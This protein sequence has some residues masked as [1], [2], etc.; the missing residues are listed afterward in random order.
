MTWNG[1]LEVIADETGVSV[2]DID[3]HDE[4]VALGI[5]DILAQSILARM[6]G[7]LGVDLPSTVFE[8]FPTVAAFREYYQ[9]HQQTSTSRVPL[10]VILQGNLGTSARTIFLLPDGSGSGMAYSGI[11]AIAPSTCLVAL[12]SPYLGGGASSYRSSIE[13]LSCLWVAE[14]RRRLAHGPYLLGGWSAGGY[15]AYEV[16]KQLLA[17]GESVH[18]LILIDSPCRVVFEAL[19]IE[20]IQY[21]ASR[22]LMGSNWGPEGTPQWLLE[23]FR[24]TLRAVDDYHPTAMSSEDVPEDT[25]IIWSRDGVQQNAATTGLDLRVKVSRFLLQGKTDFGPQGWEQLLPGT[26]INIATMSGTHFSLIS[27]PHVNELGDLLRDIVSDMPIDR[28]ARW[29]RVPGTGTTN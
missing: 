16:A 12:N 9:I 10:S 24:S 23:H 26:R 1:T 4:F 5:N 18:K 29:Q 8:Q 27:E 11:P 20:V 22:N 13:E 25:Y 14:I 19:P 2:E 21:V 15:Y 3:D 17:D 6:K 7:Q 28:Q